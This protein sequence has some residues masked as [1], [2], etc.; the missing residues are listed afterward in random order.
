MKNGK[1]IEAV[2]FASESGLTERF[3]PVSLLKS[4]LKNSKKNTTTI[5][6]NGNNSAAAMVHLISIH[7]CDFFNLEH[8]SLQDFSLG[9]FIFRKSQIQLS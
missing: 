1:E 5:L 6:K 9:K 8:S 4:Y 3:P 2:Y 7:L